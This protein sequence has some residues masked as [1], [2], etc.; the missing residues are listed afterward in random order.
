MNAAP[1]LD[2]SPGSD[3]AFSHEGAD[4]IHPDRPVAQRVHDVPASARALRRA[5]RVAFPGVP[6]SVRRNRGSGMYSWVEVAWTDGPTGDQVAAVGDQFTRHAR[7]DVAGW[8]SVPT[9][10]IASSDALDRYTLRGITYHQK[11]A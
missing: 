11:R 1:A 6:F 10:T 9:T 2:R 5:L 3:I 4:S 7:T 8:L